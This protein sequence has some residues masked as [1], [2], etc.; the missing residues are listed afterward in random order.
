MEAFCSELIVMFPEDSDL[1]MASNMIKIL[2]KSNPRKLLVVFNN[3]TEGYRTKI[4][5]RD[6]S[7]FVQH[8][9]NDIGEQ[10]G[11]KE[12]TEAIVGRLKQHWKDMSDQSKDATWRYF[13]VLFL[14]SDKLQTS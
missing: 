3:F 4:M 12:Y 10:T 2:K 1:R 8:D 5:S 9:F 14:L 13:E 11:Y 6:E 7:F